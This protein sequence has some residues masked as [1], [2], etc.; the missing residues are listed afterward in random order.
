VLGVEIGGAKVFRKVR[1]EPGKVTF[2]EF[3][4]D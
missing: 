4:P 2:V 1:V 3:R